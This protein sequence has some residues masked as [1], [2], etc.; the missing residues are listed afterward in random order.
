MKKLIL[1]SVI[2]VCSYSYGQTFVLTPNGLRDSL[3]LENNYVVVN[4]EGKT[5][6]QLYDNSM[7]YIS[8]NFN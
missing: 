3:N 7:K 5:A 6:K 2:F 4:I 8:K 1:L